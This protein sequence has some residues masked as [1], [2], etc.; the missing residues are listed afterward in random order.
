MKTKFVSM[1]ALAGAALL[2][3][4]VLA[5]L[6]CLGVEGA[7]SCTDDLRGTTGGVNIFPWETVYAAYE[8]VD[9]KN[10]KIHNGFTG[11]LDSYRLILV[12]DTGIRG[13]SITGTAAAYEFGTTTNAIPTTDEVMDDV[14]R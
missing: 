11:Q 12:K 13:T 1:L 9:V 10:I 8:E 5:Q 4:Q 3:Q 6:T 2:P 7:V 14:L